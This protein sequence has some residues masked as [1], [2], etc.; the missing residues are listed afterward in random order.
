MLLRIVGILFMCIAMMGA[1]CQNRDAPILPDN[2]PKP[3]ADYRLLEKCDTTLPPLGKDSDTIDFLNNHKVTVT[4]LDACAC[5]H[6]ALRNLA[7]KLVANK[8][9][10]ALPECEAK[11][12]AT[13][14]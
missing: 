11:I 1:T 12:D 6:I 14:K 10:D 3:R 13:A 8:P 7:C 9:C 5:R 2:I 4:K